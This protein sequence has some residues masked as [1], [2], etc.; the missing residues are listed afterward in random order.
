MFKKILLM[1]LFVSMSVNSAES[2]RT[3]ITRV[4]TSN[5]GEGIIIQTQDPA[6]T[7]CSSTSKIFMKKDTNLLFEENL[8][9]LLSAFHSGSKVLIYTEGCE[10]SSHIA[11]KSVSVIK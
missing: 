9:I 6:P 4:G 11:F 3:K 2:I 5:S 8:S 7:T 10:I 1:T